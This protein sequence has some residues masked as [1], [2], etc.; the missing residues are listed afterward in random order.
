MDII[1][2]DTINDHDMKTFETKDAATNLLLVEKRQEVLRKYEREKRLYMKR[3]MSFWDKVGKQEAAKRVVRVSTIPTM[4]D[5][6]ETA[7]LCYTHSEPKKMITTQFQYLL[8]PILTT[9]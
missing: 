6:A 5:T 2:K 7:H 8:H 9:E 1:N 3:K 4:D